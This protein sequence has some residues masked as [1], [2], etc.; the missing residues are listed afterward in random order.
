[1]LQMPVPQRCPAIQQNLPIV[2]SVPGTNDHPPGA[3]FVPDFGIT[4]MHY[5]FRRCQHTALLLKVNTIMT[6]SQTLY[7]TDNAVITT[8]IE[9]NMTSINK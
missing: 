9:T 6:C 7:F 8:I 5:T 1:M 2:R 4:E 3:V